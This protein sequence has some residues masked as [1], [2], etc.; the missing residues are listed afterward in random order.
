MK[1]LMAADVVWRA[2]LLLGRLTVHVGT[3]LPVLATLLPAL[4]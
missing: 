3:L 1:K 4:C 2:K